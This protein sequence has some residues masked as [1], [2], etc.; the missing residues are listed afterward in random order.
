MLVQHFDHR[1]AAAFSTK[2][3]SYYDANTAQIT[4]NIVQRFPQLEART[5]FPLPS[6]PHLEQLRDTVPISGGARYFQRLLDLQPRQ[7]WARY[8]VGEINI[9]L[10]A[11]EPQFFR[12]RL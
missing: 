11:V 3:S 9:C 5:I 1:L 12:Y 8:A 6:S 7:F 10:T 2:S 4:K